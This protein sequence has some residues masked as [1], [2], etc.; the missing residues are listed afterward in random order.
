M[1]PTSK[2][3]SR[4]RERLANPHDTWNNHDQALRIARRRWKRKT[5]KLVRRQAKA[6]IARI[7]FSDATASPGFGYHA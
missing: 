4:L 7:N 1:K 6:E 5:G 2:K 3:E